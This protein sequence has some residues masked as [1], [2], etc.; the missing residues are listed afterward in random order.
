MT[1]PKKVKSSSQ[2]KKNIILSYSW[3]LIYSLHVI[4]AWYKVWWTRVPMHHKI[5]FFN[6]YGVSVPIMIIQGWTSKK[7]LGHKY[8][9]NFQSRSYGM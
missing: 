8:N 5:E 4:C 6:I 3:E 7:V 1:S 2:Q 9:T